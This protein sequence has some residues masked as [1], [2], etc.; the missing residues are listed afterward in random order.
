VPTVQTSGIKIRQAL[1]DAFA[2]QANEWDAPALQLANQQ[3]RALK[4]LE[5]LAAKSPTGE[6]SPGS[7]LGKVV[8][9]YGS[10][11]KAG[12][13]GTLARVGKAFLQ[14]QKTSGTPERAVWRNIMNK[15]VTGALGTAADA[16]LALPINLIAT[17]AVNRA[18]NSPGMR[19]RLLA[20]ALQNPDASAVTMPAGASS[21]AL[22]RAL[23]Q[24]GNP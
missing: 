8:D 1:D 13:L 18:L 9:E 2:T 12:N 11:T 6:I 20:N 4:V 19:Q 17:R 14:A 23:Q 3:Y 16:T 5:P 24:S 15:P 10:A 7:L 21:E 22:A